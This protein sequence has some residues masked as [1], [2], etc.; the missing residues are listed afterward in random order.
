MDQILNEDNDPWEMID[1]FGFNNI[2]STTA[3]IAAEDQYETDELRIPKCAD[4]FVRLLDA[5]KERYCCL[6][7]PAHQLRFLD[8][9]I[10][11]IDDFRTRLVQLYNCGLRTTYILN[12]I[13]YVNSVLREWGENVVSMIGI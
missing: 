1:P 3:S 13:F 9:Q 11:L 10:K 5:M 4:Q 8:L 2:T 12:A 7:Q 6:P